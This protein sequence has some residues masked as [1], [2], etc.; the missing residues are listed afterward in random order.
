MEVGNLL[1]EHLDVTVLIK[2]PADIQPPRT[3]EFPIVRGVVR[4]AKGHLGA[5]ELTVDDFAQPAPSSRSEL[6][7]GAARNGAQSKCDVILDLTGDTPLFPASDLRDGYLRADPDHPAAVL[8]EVLQARDLVGTFEKPR[9]ITFEAGL[10]AHSRS[11]IVG[12]TSLPR[13]LS[14][15][16]HRSC[17]RP[18]CHLARR[19]ARVAASAPPRARRVRLPTPCRPPMP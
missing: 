16:G 7:F 14:R 19:S 18:R 13:P 6:A 3:T 10:C 1:K 8:K 5:F 11:R 2:P 17:R 4:A 9:Y 15:R 12:C